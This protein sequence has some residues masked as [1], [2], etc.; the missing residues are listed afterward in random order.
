MI[1]GKLPNFSECGFILPSPSLIMAGVIVALSIS[2]VIFIKLYS[3]KVEEHATYIAEVEAANAKVSED[4]ARRL[5]DAEAVV[6]DV[7][8]AWDTALRSL[9]SSYISRLRGKDS[10]CAAVSGASATAKLVNESTAQSESGSGSFETT[11]FEIE[12]NAAVDAAQ[13]LHLQSYIRGVCK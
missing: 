5:R 3:N 6:K 2:N 1:S 10:S 8:N 13:V 7:S 4:N 11:C 9:D 12:R